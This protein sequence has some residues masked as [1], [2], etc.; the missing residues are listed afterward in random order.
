MLAGTNQPPLLPTSDAATE[1][2]LLL[3][4]GSVVLNGLDFGSGAADLTEGHYPSLAALADWL[5]ANPSETVALVGHTDTSGGLDSNI[6]ISKRRAGSVRKRLIEVYGIPSAQI[7][8]QGVGY[9]SPI[10]SN[11]TEEGRQLNRRVEAILTS[12][13]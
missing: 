10:A 4:K 12:L 9:L 5:K 1:V 8:A 11:E 13:Q 7:D 6:Q 2:S 3:E